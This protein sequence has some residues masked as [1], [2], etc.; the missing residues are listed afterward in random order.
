[1]NINKLSL[2]NVIRNP[3]DTSVS[4]ILMSLG[5]A[6]ISMM[7]LISNATKNQLE[8]NL[9]GVDM[10]IGAKGSPIQVIL[11]SIFHI[12]N[13]TGN[14]SLTEVKKIVKDA[15]TS[16]SSSEH[17]MFSIPLEVSISSGNN[18]GEAH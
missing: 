12:D 10:V 6:I 13:P 15:M 2:V 16:V 3:V 17:H 4:M 7:L 5:V 14:I 18:W 1:M 8:S 9:G 11:S